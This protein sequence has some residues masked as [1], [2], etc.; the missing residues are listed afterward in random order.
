MVASGWGGRNGKGQTLVTAT[1]HWDCPKYPLIV[2]VK[3]V[4]FMCEFYLHLKGKKGN[5]E[6][7]PMLLVP[8]VRKDISK[9]GGS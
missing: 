7:L 3:I 6:M 5:P 4:I 8:E 9:T 1:Q 2:H